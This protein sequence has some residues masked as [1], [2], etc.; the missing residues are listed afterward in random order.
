MKEEFHIS[1]SNKIAL[2]VFAVFLILAFLYIRFF[3]SYSSAIPYSTTNADTTVQQEA[4]TIERSQPMSAFSTDEGAF[5]FEYP[6][7]WIQQQISESEWNISDTESSES[8]KITITVEVKEAS[9]S[10]EPLLG[11]NNDCKEE[12]ISSHLFLTKETETNKKVTSS[13]ATVL[14]ERGYVLTAIYPTDDTNTAL[15]VSSIFD[16]IIVED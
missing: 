13:I 6:A 2:G 3:A 8:A 11:C 12:N 4:I 9:D 15:Q 1:T 10:A 7:G 14:K 16:S 5:S